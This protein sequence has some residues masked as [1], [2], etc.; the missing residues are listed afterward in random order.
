MRSHAIFA[1]A[2][3]ISIAA[4]ACG[5]Q[6]ADGDVPV[7]P[8]VALQID[9]GNGCIDV[10]ETGVT[11]FGSVV[12]GTNRADLI[13]CRNNTGGLWIYALAGVD[14][15]EG[16]SGDD[17]LFGGPGCDLVRGN[18][19]NDQVTG[20]PGNDAIAFCQGGLEGGEGDDF[21]YG[22]PGNDDL[23]GAAG[24]D[25]LVGGPGRDACDPGSDPND[26]VHSSCELT[27]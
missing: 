12:V 18:G 5:G 27:G 3:I 9:L 2:L 1:I 21:I 20:G 8:V 6:D 10:K 17:F 4:A 11:V 7:D 26:A 25:T 24:A 22:G 23:F 16:G 15:I 13:D 14:T 19:G